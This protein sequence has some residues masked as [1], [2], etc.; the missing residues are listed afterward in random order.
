MKISIES[1]PN[2]RTTSSWFGLV[3][4]REY[5]DGT[6]IHVTVHFTEEEKEI[7]RRNTTLQ[8][9]LIFEHPNDEVLYNEWLEAR[10]KRLREGGGAGGALADQKNYPRYRLSRLVS[11]FIENPT[12]VIGPI[13]D[14]VY[15]VTSKKEVEDNLVKLKGYITTISEHH[16]PGKRELDL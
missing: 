10:E 7:I 11:H 15:L 9:M 2:I 1:K 5:Q 12:Q 16:P 3:K 4:P 6:N 8:D 13:G 14:D